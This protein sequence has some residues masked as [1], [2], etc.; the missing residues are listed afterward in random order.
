[1]TVV[2]LSEL[3]SNNSARN[4]IGQSQGDVHDGRS[5]TGTPS[6]D[7][8]SDILKNP[9]SIQ[10]MLRNTT[11]TGNVGQFSIKPSRV[12]PSLPRPSKARATPSKQRQPGAHYNRHE[13][14]N[15]LHTP[16]HFR[17]E[18]IA[19]NGSGFQNQIPRPH[20]A[21]ARSP[22]FEDYRSYSTT[23]SS[24]ASH[25][26]ATHHTHTNVG[27][28][29][30][31]GPHNLRPRSP[32]AYPTRLKR[33]GYRPSSPALSEFNKQNRSQTSL[34]RRPSFRTNSPSSLHTNGAP[35]P[36]RKGVNRSDPLLRYYPQSAVSI[37][38]I[39]SSPSP[40]STRPPTPKASPSLKSI[41]NSTNS[42]QATTTNPSWIHPQSP[43]PLPIFYDYTEDFEE[44]G[45]EQ[46]DYSHYV[47]MSTGT[48][49]EQPMLDTATT[50]YYELAASPDTT[51]GIELQSDN[52]FPKLKTQVTDNRFDQTTS[53]FEV[54]DQ[55]SMQA[56][57]K[58]L[59]EVPE[60]PEGDVSNAEVE[61]ARAKHDDGPPDQELLNPFPEQASHFLATAEQSKQSP[62]QEQPRKSLSQVEI[63]ASTWR[64]SRSPHRPTSSLVDSIHSVKS[65]LQPVSERED[66]SPTD[67]NAVPNTVASPPLV[68]Q[69][70]AE[71]DHGKSLEGENRHS[72]QLIRAVSLEDHSGNEH[73]VTEIISPT[74]ERSVTSPSNVSRF[75]KIL[76]I[77]DDLLDLD[78]LANRIKGK[79]RANSPMHSIMDSR[80]RVARI[81]PPWRKLSV[82]LR[83]I[84]TRQN[85]ADY[86]LVEA[87]DSEGEPELTPGLRQ[88]FCKPD[89]SSL[90]DQPGS[91]PITLP[92]QLVHRGYPGLLSI[93]RSPAVRRSTS[94]IRTVQDPPNAHP[95]E[96]LRSPD[97]NRTHIAL[98]LDVKQSS[99]IQSSTHPKPE[100]PT[101]YSIHKSLIPEI[102][103]PPPPDK[104]LPSLP[105]ER[106]AVVSLSPPVAP[107]L[108]SLPF[109]FTPLIQR[110]SEE[111]TASVAEV[112]TVTSPSLCQGEKTHKDQG[113]A[114][115]TSATKFGLD[116]SSTASSPDS[117]PWNLDTSY[118]WTDQQPKLEVTMPEPTEDP[119]RSTRSLP[120]F[121]FKVQRASSTTEG[122]GKITRYPLS[123]DAS[124][125][126]FASSQD[127]FQGTA[128]RRKRYP[129]L[130]VMPG[131]I[132]SS[133][134]VI[135]TSPN[136]T[137]FV[138]S[139]ETQSPRITLVPPSPGFEA[140][141][142]FSDDSSQFRPRG[143]FRKRFS[144]LRNRT[145]RGASTD[146]PRGYD[147]GL[148]SSAL[149]RS[150]ASGR[151]SRQSENTAITTVASSHASQSKR[152]GRKLVKKIRSWWQR[153][154]DRVREWRWRRRYDGA[155]GRSV[156]ADL[157]AGV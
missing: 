65:V 91:P 3:P 126:P 90:D 150:R 152:A 48:L 116:R 68:G 37:A 75:S 97:G 113:T 149:G 39:G 151:S 74:P 128:F 104:E 143:A 94:D 107:R 154:E 127:T 46:Q 73:T 58:D 142:F 38:G 99:P 21:P 83:D 111:E 156:S 98:N 64:I 28:S 109:K 144:E 29:G 81:E 7:E 88:T 41:A 141:S 13:D 51:S 140:R 10:S 153:G 138:E 96:D 71:S 70:A 62:D 47:S 35:S 124:P 125:S 108:L 137:R 110:R 86:A 123:S 136:R 55:S 78:E 16:L 129:T 112:E 44:Q 89:D 146:E 92:S 115:P 69:L 139:F 121:R 9:S 5:R 14:S 22:S 85:A 77:N 27:H 122:T 52:S 61:T 134:D 157:Y 117:R 105:D 93:R 100:S 43:S 67:W 30:P 148:L 155:V 103:P 80:T 101:R 54:D 106:P 119:N 72:V 42:L 23:K 95:T 120:R 11:E 60:L 50:T 40:T 66:S 45:V 87:S 19:F 8:N 76:S 4:G 59:S 102:K 133:H 31:G 82:Q 6:A 135:R 15:I 20:R 114:M 17:Q 18:T 56:L 49:A 57:H 12:P 131:Q 147:R 130:S 32:F 1:M 33:P 25:S 84:S 132:N 36:W 26:H 145:S 34:H 79:D 53:Q 118:P 63:T 2:P 24:Y